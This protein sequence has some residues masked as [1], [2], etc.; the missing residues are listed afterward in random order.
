MA[1]LG[2]HSSVLA[3]VEGLLARSRRGGRKTLQWPRCAPHFCLQPCLREHVHDAGRKPKW[4]LWGAIQVFWRKWRDCLRDPGGEGGKHSNGRAARPI[5]VYS[6]AYVNTFTTRAG[7]QNGPFGGPFKC[8]GGSGGIRTPGTLRYNGFQ[9]RR[10]RPLCHTPGV[11]IENLFC[12]AQVQRQFGWRFL[13]KS[14]ADLA[15]GQGRAGA[16]S[17]TGCLGSLVLGTKKPQP[18]VFPL[19]AAFSLSSPGIP[20]CAAGGRWYFL[21]CSRVRWP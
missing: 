15:R 20:T 2:G 7:N 3:E 5:F 16:C 8:F 6:P 12:V 11:K 4:P 9:D 13:L 1:P 17:A 18:M 10:V 19:L 14:C 21:W